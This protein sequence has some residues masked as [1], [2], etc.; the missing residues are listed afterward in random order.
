MGLLGLLFGKPERSEQPMPEVQWPDEKPRYEDDGR[1]FDEKLKEILA[2][3]EILENVD[4]AFLELQGGR[5]IWKRGGACCPPEPISYIVRRDGA[6]LL[7]IRYWKS[8]GEYDHVANRAI[9][10]YCMQ[11]G[12]KVLEFFDYLP[13][14][15]EYMKSR[16]MANL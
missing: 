5:E 3:Y 9:Q 2:G 11:N 16:I 15:P 7:Y 8:Y 1:S 10:I 4:P 12:K 13:N 6:E 14:D